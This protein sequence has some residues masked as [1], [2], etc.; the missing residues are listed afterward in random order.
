MAAMTCC[1]LGL[2]LMAAVGR[3]R[4]LFGGRPKDAALFA[5]VARRPAP[6]EELPVAEPVSAGPAAQIRDR[7]AVFDYTALAIVL[8]ALAAP[9]L[10][11]AGVLHNTGSA[12]P[13]V[14]RSALYGAAAAAAL[15]LSRSTAIWR[16]P[17][18]AGTLLVILG[19]V[20]FEVS[21]LD[22]HVFGLFDIEDANVLGMMVF[23]NIG[24]AV[25]VV[26]GLVLAY[27]SLGRS[28]TSWRSSRS[29][30]STALPSSSAVTMSST[31]PLT[32]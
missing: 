19:T 29:T 24:P 30:V 1:I 4:R 27:G 28:T 15:A 10:V 5:P 17:K 25:A 8:C 22:M 7:T 2:L 31:A 11:L 26:G 13:W 6:G 23:H 9:A 12:V 20:I 32:R 16:A 21:V 3:I 18:G 14:L